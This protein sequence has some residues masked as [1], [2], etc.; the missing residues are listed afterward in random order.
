MVTLHS[1]T[2]FRL[3]WRFFCRGSTPL[4]C[5]PTGMVKK[6]RFHRKTKKNKKTKKRIPLES[7]GFAAAGILARLELFFFHHSSGMPFLDEK[8]IHEFQQ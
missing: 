4:E 2:L 3:E 7:E 5:V 8:I 1:A 6:K